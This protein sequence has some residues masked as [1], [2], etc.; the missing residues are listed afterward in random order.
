MQFREDRRCTFNANVPSAGGEFG[1]DLIMI[2]GFVVMTFVWF[3]L[4]RLL[5]RHA[6]RITVLE[7]YGHWVAPIVLILVGLYILDNTATDLLSG[8]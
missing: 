8:E 6:T 3:G 7:R 4:A 1:V 5:E 2:S